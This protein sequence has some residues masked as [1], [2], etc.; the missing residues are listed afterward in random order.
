MAKARC[1]NWCFISCRLVFFALGALWLSLVVVSHVS[2]EEDLRQAEIV[3]EMSQDF[4]KTLLR[5]PERLVG[6]KDLHERVVSSA[7]ERD[8][9]LSLDHFLFKLP[10]VKRKLLKPSDVDVVGKLLASNEIQ[11]KKVL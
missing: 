5:N 7:L 1:A 4:A 10:G 9:V 3:E 11:W 2:V 8:D 6:T